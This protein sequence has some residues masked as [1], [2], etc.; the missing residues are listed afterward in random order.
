MNFLGKWTSKT[1]ILSIFL[2][3]FLAY[4]PILRNNFVWDDEEQVV[5]NSYI[6][7]F[8]NLPHIFKGSTFASGG[9]GL[10]GWYYKPLMSLWFM[11]NYR[12]WGLNP[13]GFHLSQLVLHLVNCALIFI[14]F[15]KLFK[16][17]GDQKAKLVGFCLA[18]VFAVHPANAESVAYISASQELL[19]T[20]F[21]LLT[22]LFSLA[23]EKILVIIFSGVFFF[24]ALLSKESAIVGLPIIVLY[25]WQAGKK[26][27]SLW[28]ALTLFSSFLIYFYL[29]TFVAKIP[30]AKPEL[31]PIAAASFPQRLLTVPYLLF[32]YLRLIFFPLNLFIA[33]HQVVREVGEIRFV[34]A[35]IG[36]VLFL[37]M[38][39]RQLGRFTSNLGR[40]FFFWFLVSLGLV[41]NLFPLDM[42]LAE[43]WL[44]WPILG[45]LGMLG[46]LLA[47]GRDKK[48]SSEKSVNSLLAFGAIVLLLAGRTF[49]RTLDWHDGLT[50]YSRDLKL[51][52]DAFDLQNNY[53]VEL[54]RKGKTEEAA[55]H[56]ERSIA[57]SPGWW[58]N[59]SNLG[60]VYQRRG[61]LAKARE[62]YQKAIA[63]GDYYLAYENLASLLLKTEKPEQTITFLDPAL[64]KFPF[65]QFLRKVLIIALTRKADFV[66]AEK[67]ADWLYRLSPTEE[68]RLLY[69][70]VL[71]KQKL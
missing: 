26:K 56:F 48:E 3:G 58:T 27:K 64:K 61:D 63:N 30:L 29:R 32:S 70:M 36:V 10:T 62:L 23:S 24:L 33:Q 12:L 44:Y 25:F 46:I 66:L 13:A 65:N 49:L 8:T 28:L 57:L 59:Y 42:T 18:I 20:F 9:A 67:E 38:M 60:V 54:V 31:S 2:I 14:L 6:R 53:G 34:G 51:N 45:I 69:E 22:F 39:V 1:L 52:P 15:Q 35:L 4:T 17:F 19:Y 50:L 16:E 68:N 5:N 11:L 7:S 41:L 71:K 47:Q 37:F 21:L 55:S 40:F 43:R